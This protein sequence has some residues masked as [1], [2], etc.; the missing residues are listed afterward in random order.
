MI[1][2][3][4]SMRGMSYAL[5]IT[6]QLALIQLLRRNKDIERA[7]IMA[8][9]VVSSS[10]ALF[11]V[12]SLSARLALRALEHLLMDQ[13]EW[14]QALEV[15]SSAVGQASS[16]EERV[17]PQHHDECAIYTMEDI[18]KIYDNLGRPES[19]IAW[20]DRAAK[21][22]YNLFGSCAATTHIIDKLVSAFVGSGEH[23]DAKLWQ[24]IRM[25]RGDGVL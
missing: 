17:E 22:A 24:W 1:D 18:A 14:R 2:L 20:L 5:T 12:H 25:A 9:T 10:T 3:L 6:T 21:S 16:T 11:G 23:E 4:T 8:R 13:N 7:G 15:C 19:C